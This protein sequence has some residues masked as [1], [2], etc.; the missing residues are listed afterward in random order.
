M[1]AWRFVGPLAWMLGALPAVS[2]AQN[3]SLPAGVP[4]SW[5]TS[6]IER[7]LNCQ[8]LKYPAMLGFDFRYWTGVDFILGLEQ[9]Q[10]LGPGRRLYLLLRATP[11][12]RPSRFFMM[13]QYLPA[14]GQL[15]A[16]VKAKSLQMQIGGG[17]HLG[18][19]KYRIDAMVVSHDGRACRVNWK[20]EAKPIAEPLRQE[21]LTVETWPPPRPASAS[22]ASA[23]QQTR[24]RVAIIA[25]AD[26]F[27]PRRYSAKLG[28][29]DRSALVDS[30][31]SLVDTWDTADFSLQ[32]LHLERR[33]VL[34]NEP[35][36]QP[37]TFGRVDDAL[38]R[39]DTQ[40]VDL[41]SLRRGARADFFAQFVERES[42]NW[43]GLDA[44]VFLGPAW[45]WFDK[46]PGGAR[47]KQRSLPKLYH[48]ALGP[49]RFPP[50]NLFK[51]FVDAQDGQVFRVNWPADLARGIKKIR[52]GQ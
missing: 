24:Q 14:P 2:L 18:L 26:T 37:T 1:Q 17:V 15:P 45:R 47:A 40:T 39:L 33:Q 35:S 19:G 31:Q 22:A 25:N 4:D 42:A 49:F 11:E 8:S 27:G 20:A 6:R 10:P 38:R 51:Q 36:I 50:E 32:L 48:L 3:G 28:A 43:E 46:L 9:F 7:Q 13:Q 29:R 41:D 23:G 5:W 16:D 44:V 12:G 52:T 34:L 30:L 21:P